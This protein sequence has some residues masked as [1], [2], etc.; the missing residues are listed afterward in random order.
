MQQR[1]LQKIKSNLNNLYIHYLK[2]TFYGKL[3]VGLPK[4]INKTAN[5][6]ITAS[7]FYPTEQYSDFNFYYR[8]V[9]L[10]F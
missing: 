2:N 7:S 5:L 4:K 9:G 6:N 10:Q 1:P 8:S 3:G